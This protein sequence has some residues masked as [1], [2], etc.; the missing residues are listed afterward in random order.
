MR[1]SANGNFAGSPN[2]WTWQSQA[3]RG[4]SKSTAVRPAAAAPAR[5]AHAALAAA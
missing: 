5:S 4:T 1:F 2:T 3:P